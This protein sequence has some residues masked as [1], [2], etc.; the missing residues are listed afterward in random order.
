VSY[1]ELVRQHFFEPKHAFSSNDN[2]ED[3]ILA[4]K[5]AIALGDAVEFYLQ[6]DLNTKQIKQ[7][8]FKAYGNPYLIAAMSYWCERLQ[9]KPLK[10][11]E[12]FSAQTL[13]DELALPK[14]KYYVA[15]MVED[16]LKSLINL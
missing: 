5:G 10:E 6:C 16:A 14:T 1:N 4:S 9:N 13:I 15:Y 8:K 11:A 12:N 3:F 2:K 7:L